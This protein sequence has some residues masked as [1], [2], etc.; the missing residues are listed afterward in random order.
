MLKKQCTLCVKASR[1][2]S[3][4]FGGF[5]DIQTLRTAIVALFPNLENHEMGLFA[6]LE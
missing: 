3:R 4:V 2:F 1:F 5:S 6:R